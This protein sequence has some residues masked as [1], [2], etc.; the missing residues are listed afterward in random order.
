MELIQGCR[1]KAEQEQLR[2]TIEPYGIVWLPEK[3]CERALELFAQNH[4]S[5]GAGMLDVLIG[6]TAV[7]LEDVPTF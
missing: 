7:A 1:N 4:L 3:H 2:H 6:Q 5:H